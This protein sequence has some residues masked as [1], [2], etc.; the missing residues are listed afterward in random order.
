M[1][2]PYPKDR[3]GAV[4]RALASHHHRVPFPALTPYI[5]FLVGSRPFSEGFSSFFLPPQKPTHPV[6]LGSRPKVT[7]LIGKFGPKPHTFSSVR[8]ISA[9]RSGN[10]AASLEFSQHK[11]R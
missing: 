10:E 4:V 3:D 2:F 11:S 1:F 5:E 8:S 7:S 6:V 9:I